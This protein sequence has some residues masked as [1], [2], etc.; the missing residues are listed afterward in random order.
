MRLILRAFAI[1]GL[2]A[3]AASRAA[4]AQSGLDALTRPRDSHTISYSSHD[5]KRAND[6]YRTI[7]PGETLTLL[8]HT[9]AGVIRRWWVTIAPRNNREIQR[10]LIVRCW[11]DDEPEP[12]VE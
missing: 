2:T 9:G 10:Q 11:W 4:L 3:A 12:S 8:D 7:A 6:D 5:P 1:G